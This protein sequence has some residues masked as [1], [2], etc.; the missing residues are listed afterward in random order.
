MKDKWKTMYL[1]IAALIAEYSQAQKLKVGAVFVSE[2]EV[3]SLGINGLP[4]G[5]SNVCEDSVGMTLLEVAHA[6]ENLIFKL[7]KEGVSTKNGTLFVTHS[8]C[9]RC[10][11]ILANAGISKIYYLEQH[12]DISLSLTYLQ[13][14]FPEI[15]MR[16]MYI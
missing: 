2:N 15:E 11:K 14:N 6:E 1:R 7:L 8:P 3:L 13:N 12:K 10:T 16:Q 9:I 4:S 5:G